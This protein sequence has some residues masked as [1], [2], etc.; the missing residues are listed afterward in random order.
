MSNIENVD[1]IGDNLYL[2]TYISNSTISKYKV[3]LILGTAGLYFN[4]QI[5]Y[6]SIIEDISLW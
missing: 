1:C 6:A 2:D 3:H 5:Q 4:G